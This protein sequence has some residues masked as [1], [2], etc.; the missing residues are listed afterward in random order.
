VTANGGR[1]GLSVEPEASRPQPLPVREG[2]S[3]PSPQ[4]PDLSAVP[5][6]SQLGAGRP[7]ATDERERYGR[8]LDRPVDGVRVHDGVPM[9]GS[10]AGAWSAGGHVVLSPWLP[11]DQRQGAL[12][13][14]VVHAAGQLAAPRGAAGAAP[15][16]S[17][18]ESATEAAVTAMA[19]GVPATVPLDP[20][21]VPRGLPPGKDGEPLVITASSFEDAAR[22][23]QSILDEVKAGGTTRYTLVGRTAVVVFDRDG[24]ALG[25]FRLR[26]PARIASG[27]HIPAP[28]STQLYPLLRS[29]SGYRRGPAATGGDIDFG[30]DITKQE[31][32]DD[33]ARGHIMIYVVPAADLAG[34]PPSEPT[35][36][37]QPDPLMQ[38][39]ATAQANLP[40]WP[41]Y[42]RAF[43]PQVTAT[44]STGS[45]LMHVENNQG[46]SDLDRVTNLMQRIN[47]NWQVLK[48][49]AHFMPVDGAIRS[50]TRW[51]ATKGK[52]ERRAR[53]AEADRQALLGEHPERQSLPARFVKEAVA[54]QVHDARL[55]LS[56]TG[57]V[58]S[59]VIDSLVGGPENPFSEDIMDVQFREPGD[60]FVRCLA[61]PVSGAGSKY[62]RASTVGGVTV[63]VFDI[64]EYA[65]EA[66]GT[67]AGEAGKAGQR[68]AAIDAA[69]AAPPSA[70]PDP[71]DQ[72]RQA[73]ERAFLG[74]ERSYFQAVIDAKGDQGAILAARRDYLLARIAWLSGPALPPGDA[75]FRAAV[76]DE[77]VH[78]RD[79]EQ[80][81]RSTIDLARSRLPSDVTPTGLMTA[82]LIDEE[83]GARL[84]M[85]FSLGERRYV[86]ADQLEVIIA[87]ITGGQAGRVFNGRGDGFQGAGRPDAVRAAMRDLRKNLK[88]GRGELAYRLPTRYAA[89]DLDL[90]NPM[91]LQ[92]SA[93][94]MAAETADDAAHALTLAAL[95]AAPFTDFASLEILAVLAPVQAATSLYRIVDRAVYQDLSLDTAL[96]MDFIN[97]A[98]A[99][100]GGVGEANQL[101]SRGVQIAAGAAGVAVKLLNYGNYVVIGWQTF[102]DLTTPD[103]AGSDPREGRQRRLRALLSALEAVAIHA[104]GE[105]K[106]EAGLPPAHP[107]PEPAAS[108]T[109]REEGAPPSGRPGSHAGTAAGTGQRPEPPPTARTESAKA[110]PATRSELPDLRRGLP[111]DLA[112]FMHITQDTSPGF[113]G[114]TVHV[115]YTAEG[116]IITDIRL[117]VGPD[118]TFGEIAEHV[119]TIR[120]MQRYQ[121]LAGHVRALLDRITAWLT[122]NPLAGPGSR[123]WEARLELEK[124][125][126]IIEARAREMADPAI[127]P[128]RRAELELELS[129]LE[130]QLARHAADVDSA[131]TGQGFVAA[132]GISA[133]KAEA[134]R[135]GYPKLPD[136]N[137]EAS[138]GTKLGEYIWRYTAGDKEPEVVRRGDG[139]KLIYDKKSGKF[140][141]DTRTRAEPSFGTTTTPAEAFEAL[142]GRDPELEFGK[143]THMLVAEGV[144]RGPEAIIAAM[145]DPAGRQYRTVRS[146]LKDIYAQAVVDTITDPTRLH[147]TPLFQF[148][149]RRGVAPEDAL[150]QASHAEMLRVTGNLSS[151]DRGAVAERWYAAAFGTASA[152]Q[153]TITPEQASAAGTS[154]STT[155]RLD[156]V[157]GWFIEELKN[158]SG[159]LDADD[160]AQI[161]DQLR[162]VDRDIPL[163]GGKVQRVKYL[164]VSMLD[165]EGVLAN[166]GYMY[167]R[168]DPSEPQA[169]ELMFEIWNSRG[170]SLLVTTENRAILNDPAKLKAYLAYGTVQ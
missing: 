121:G 59:Q 28:G 118:A 80:Q 41:G 124:L 60:Y 24:T 114:H 46:I 123:A 57:E 68:I 67:E 30:H 66:L 1:T 7:L 152:Q 100:L 136:P 55:I 75:G 4:S 127:T 79:E 159:R 149:R 78:L 97:I 162:L 94:D 91:Q 53:N 130:Q 122:R 2:A 125:P 84:D 143:F 51:D 15:S 128:A 17:A 140:V 21:S 36:T 61:T 87:D 38:F 113:G 168:L 95:L 29:G 105:L 18:V 129:D 165:P 44:N 99:G 10:G 155:R 37:E 43:T 23:F 49:D 22:Q 142:G 112:A 101:A 160:Q 110:R 58:V 62:Q 93:L 170:T 134:E 103:P 20:G 144:V 120:S 56:V 96:V 5:L 137:A 25:T 13:H 69:L 135:R 45:F 167:K 81:A 48:L 145:K 153:V 157:S 148:L 89:I 47:F 158:V 104:A 52:F 8:L 169:S 133:G 126:P 92:L 117:R 77:L 31:E 139:P 164:K 86:V 161:E 40:P 65:K 50:A 85:T 111:D 131:A 64:A 74:F 19:W 73:R 138:D 90:P 141:P 33:L 6:W 106:S 102:R 163:G 3:A 54:D 76:R 146:N 32:F 82:V 14:E 83:S 156:R 39:K 42:V 108:R 11:A 119:T 16:S 72:A 26:I 12:D 150:A 35:S 71:G 27:V 147:A 115:E 98:T 154:I 151:S 107:P 9:P 70:G 132:E 109:A 88:R 63:S 34:P 166:A 116:G